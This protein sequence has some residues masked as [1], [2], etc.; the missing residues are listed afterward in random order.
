MLIL[1]GPEHTFKSTFCR[2]LLPIP[3]QFL[4][5]EV[6][7]KVNNA[8]AER[9]FVR[10]MGS[11]AIV[12]IDEFEGMMDMKSHS[13]FFKNLLS[14]DDMSQVDIYSSSETTLQRRAIIIATT[15]DVTHVLSREGSRRL[16]CIPTGNIDTNRMLRLKHHL[17]Y[18]KLRNT[19]RDSYREGQYVWQFTRDQ[20]LLRTSWNEGYAATTSLASSLCDM[21][22]FDTTTMPEHYLKGVDITR[23]KTRGLK[24]LSTL[25]VS[26]MLQQQGVRVSAAQ[27]KHE[28]QR[29]CS[30]WTDT[31][32]QDKKFSKVGYI[33]KGKACQTWYEPRK[34]YQYEYWVMPPRDMS[35]PFDL[36]EEGEDE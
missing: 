14:S 25:E 20:S 7:Q 2:M 11:K 4:R 26:Q 3:L 6:N 8:K 10:Y 27:L 5:K 21:F 9:D 24:C 23:P 18:N 17:L 28:L 16:W 36:R 12:Q 32:K 19:L 33:I 30:M 1:V 22:P 34:K 31:V 15:N 29:L 13:S 35:I